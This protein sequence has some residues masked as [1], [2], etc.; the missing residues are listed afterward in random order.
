MTGKLKE[1]LLDAVHRLGAATAKEIAAL[2]HREGGEHHL[3]RHLGQLVGMGMLRLQGQ[4]Y[5]LHKDRALNLM[6][7]RTFNGEAE[8]DERVRTDHDR[9]REN[10]RDAWEKGEVRSENATSEKRPYTPYASRGT[11]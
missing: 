3:K 4:K 10:F 9:H 1:A 5:V 11:R 7:E 8:T 2:L 6:L